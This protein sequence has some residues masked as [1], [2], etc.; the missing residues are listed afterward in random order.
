MIGLQAHTDDDHITL[1]SGL[2]PIN[3]V[4]GLRYLA[5]IYNSVC[6]C[7]SRCCM[8]VQS[9]LVS[10]RWIWTVKADGYSHHL[11]QTL[12]PWSSGMFVIYYT[13]NARH[14][15]LAGINRSF[16]VED[17]NDDYVS[18]VGCQSKPFWRYTDGFVVTPSAYEGV[19]LL[20][21][22]GSASLCGNDHSSQMS[23]VVSH[24][25]TQSESKQAVTVT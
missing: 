1:R 19:I 10:G 21:L 14:N 15:Q 8:C 3:S 18:C 16:A 13:V 6:R 25:N 9:L 24:P 4:F 5:L 11:K 7:Q 20:L 17:S 22:R 12:R 2:D 23:M